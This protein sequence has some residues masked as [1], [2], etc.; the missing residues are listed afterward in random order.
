MEIRPAA[1]WFRGETSV[2]V[3]GGRGCGSKLSPALL[4]PRALANAFA[5][6]AIPKTRRSLG[7]IAFSNPYPLAMVTGA[8]TL[9]YPSSSMSLE[10][11][12]KPG[13]VR[14]ERRVVTLSGHASP[15]KPIRSTPS[16]SRPIVHTSSTTWVTLETTGG[17]GAAMGPSPRTPFTPHLGSDG[18]HLSFPPQFHPTAPSQSPFSRQFPSSRQV[19]SALLMACTTA[20]AVSTR[21]KMMLATAVVVLPIAK[22]ERKLRRSTA[23][24]VAPSSI[25]ASPFPT[26]STVSADDGGDE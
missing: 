17:T 7:I 24:L 1:S 16:S 26:S 15:Y 2:C 13:R 9:P 21:P 3:C 8:D 19:C 6:E 20:L 23:R 22:F 14:K 10:P 4:R 5:C 11:V 12:T 18:S 25:T